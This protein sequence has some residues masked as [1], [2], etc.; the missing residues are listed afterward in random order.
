MMGSRA[1]VGI[2]T[3]PSAAAH[4]LMFF[5]ILAGLEE[6]EGVALTAGGDVQLE[7]EA[8]K[9]LGTKL[10]GVYDSAEDLLRRYQ[11]VCSFVSLEPAHSPP[12]IALALDHGSHVMAE[13]PASLRWEDFAPLVE[14][15]AAKQR[16]LGLA[17]AGR[18]FPF[19]QD[20]RRVVMQGLLG[21]LFGVDTYFI[22]DQARVQLPAWQA[23]WYAQKA[24]A[25]GGHLMWLG[26]HYVD[27]LQHITGQHI[28]EVAAFTG[29]VGGAPIDT[30]DA[31]VAVLRF[32]NG[33]LGTLTSAYYLD[34][35]KQ[36][37][38]HLWG[39][40]GWLRGGPNEWDSLEWYSTHP[41]VVP[42]PLRRIVYSTPQRSSY[43]G[44][45]RSH[46]RASLG[47]EAPPVSGEECLSVLKVVHAIYRAAETGK[48][49]KVE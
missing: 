23:T 33:M 35:D 31:A 34:R 47:L 8:A 36:S 24:K 37:W 40:Q 4:V 5:E 45:V 44:L 3:E 46:V 43:Y 9:R 18:Q 13:K 21:K 30:E 17:F 42:A 38:F 27:L 12:I 7:Q 25:G 29:V 49:Q 22:A 39:E 26:I 41:S 20:A 15:A 28:V 16:N 19:V 2:I 48:T 11:P 10:A 1:R 6:T 32:A 14:R